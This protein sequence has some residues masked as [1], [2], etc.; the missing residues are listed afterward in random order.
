MKSSIVNDCNSTRNREAALQFGNQV[1]RFRNVGTRRR[2]RT[3][4]GRCGHAVAR[5]TVVLHDRQ[6]VALYT[7]A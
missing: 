3:E 7:F 2:P 4:Y 6:D 1:T 5:L